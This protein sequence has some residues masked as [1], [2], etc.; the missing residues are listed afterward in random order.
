[1]VGLRIAVV[2]AG[3][4][5]LACAWRLAER[6][7][8]VALI[9]PAPGSG[10]S[11]VAAGMLAPLTEAHPSEGPLLALALAAAERY[12]AFVG[13]LAAASGQPLSSRTDGTLAIAFDADDRAQLAVLARHLGEL[14][15]SAEALSARECRNLEPGLAP[16]GARRAAGGRRPQRRQP[17]AADGVARGVRTGR[18]CERC[19]RRAVRVTDDGER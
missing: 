10:A 19:A 9:D 4:I 5:G 17:C 1:M 12:P 13:D 15:L 18:R 14:G 3:V 16:G 6:G 2:G 7:A 8:E 11:A